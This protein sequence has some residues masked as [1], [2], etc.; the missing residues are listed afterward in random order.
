MKHLKNSL[1]YLTA[2]V[3][4]GSLPPAAQGQENPEPPKPAAQAYPPLASGEEGV[5]PEPR[6]PALK[7]DDNPLTGVQDL[8]L[9]TRES[10]SYWVPGFQFSNTFQNNGPSSGKSEDWNSVSYFLGSLSI[11]DSW[12][13]A[14]LTVNY[15]GGGSESSSSDLLNSFYHQLALTQ[16]FSWW[17]WRLLFTDQFSYLP[18]TPFGF[19]GVSTISIPGVGA[20]IG[21]GLPGVQ[22]NYSPSQS[23]FTGSGSRYSNSSIVQV[24]YRVSPRTSLTAAGS[25]GFLRFT[26]AGNIENN[27]ASGS[28]GY[29]YRLSERNTLGLQYRFSDF[30]YLGNPQALKDHVGQL[31]YG[32]KITGRM[33]LDVF[34]GSDVTMFR[35]PIGGA[36]HQVAFSGQATLNY[37]FAKF[38]VWLTYLHGLSNGSGVL[39]GSNT[40]QVQTQFSR[41]LAR[42]WQGSAGFGYAKNRQITGGVIKSSPQDFDTWF[43][44]AGL[45]H[46]LGRTASFSL[47]YTGRFQSGRQQFCVN[48]NCGSSY[49]QHQI[50]VGFQWSTHPFIIH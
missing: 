11:Y 17:R 42:K 29:N 9:G 44:S 3:L 23:I 14:Q 24:E 12:R 34:A 4:L 7:P 18:E 22:G 50:W 13:R 15:T 26:K 25:F 10:R 20:S 47:N 46:P 31:A 32:R 40:D 16:Q 30:R 41:Q 21:T 5:S 19:G 1:L 27:D 37:N 38:R 28:L 33:A 45:N 8:T 48:L 36:T 49:T 39:I 43:G 35:V 2:T 6:A